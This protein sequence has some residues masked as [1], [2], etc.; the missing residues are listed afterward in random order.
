[1]M[2]YCNDNNLALIN[3]NNNQIRYVFAADSTNEFINGN[4]D[5]INE[6]GFHSS[7]LHCVTINIG[8]FDKYTG[9]P[10]AGVINQPFFKRDLTVR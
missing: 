5:N 4:V 2:I 3:N 8:L 1:M 10:I 7:G 9:K 6:Y